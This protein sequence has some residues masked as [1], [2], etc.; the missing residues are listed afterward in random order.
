MSQ[1]RH[2]H[3]SHSSDRSA[4]RQGTQFSLKTLC[5]SIKENTFDRGLQLDVVKKGILLSDAYR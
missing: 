4:L 3:S 5:F 2:M 1:G